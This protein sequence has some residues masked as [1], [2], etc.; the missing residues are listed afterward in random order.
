MHLN[1]VLTCVACHSS[2]SSPLPARTMAP[3]SQPTWAANDAT[4]RTASDDEDDS[5]ADGR[6]LASL[7]SSPFAGETT[8]LGF[9]DG[10]M[11]RA[12]ELADWRVSRV[13]GVPVSLTLLGSAPHFAYFPM[14]CSCITLVV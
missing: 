11:K 6:T 7:S 8:V 5:T 2:H 13:G 4:M 1:D 12:D 14:L 10:F 3:P 9:V